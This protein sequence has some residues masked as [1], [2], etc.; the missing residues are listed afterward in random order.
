MTD[1]DLARVYA[2]ARRVRSGAPGGNRPTP[3]ELAALAT[4]DVRGAEREALLERALR[5]GAMDEL[6]LLRSVV[7]AAAQASDG[8]SRVGSAAEAPR[9]VAR[10]AARW[11][12]AAAAAAVLLTLGVPGMRRLRE[13]GSPA[14]EPLT[15]YRA[16]ESSR[17]QLLAPRA[18]RAPSV[19]EQFVW[20]AVPGAAEYV[21][22]LVDANGQA[23]A[24]VPTRDTLA[25][26]PDSLPESQLRSAEGW[27]VIATSAG[28]VQSRSALRLFR[29]PATR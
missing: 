9:S 10:V 25:V 19:R 7:T 5:S 26:L 4:G 24:R 8:E 21:L 28:G 17:P 6:S 13:F 22:E 12:P 1:D 3:D 14:A 2:A 16:S 29:E 18:E 15:T 20:S 11:W 23:V 27:W